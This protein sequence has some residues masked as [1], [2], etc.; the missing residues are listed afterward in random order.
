MEIVFKSKR[1]LMCLLLVMSDSQPVV[2]VMSVSPV[3]FVGQSRSRAFVMSVSLLVVLCY[4]GQSTG[5][6]L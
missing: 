2:F 5:R 1:L 6:V 4:V 3:C